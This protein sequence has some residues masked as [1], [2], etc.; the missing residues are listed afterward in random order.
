M[1]NDLVI[2]ISKRLY[3]L[4][5]NDYKIDIDEKKQGFNP[6]CFFI[7]DLTVGQDLIIRNRYKRMHSFDIQYFPKGG[8]KITAECRSVKETL[9][10]GME[11]ISIGSDLIRG[12]N[13]SAEIHDD[14]LHF[15]VDYNFQLFRVLDQA[16]KMQ[17]LQQ[18]QSVKE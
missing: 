12:T 7:A 6:P 9:L 17:T 5:G 18:Y 11:Y 14:V 3:E 1:E 16:P 10:M 2:A 8:E 13:M 15:F 4:F